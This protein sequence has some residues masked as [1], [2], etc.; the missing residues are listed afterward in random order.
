MNNQAPTPDA[1][2]AQLRQWLEDLPLLNPELSVGAVFEALANFKQCTLLGKTRLP[3]LH[4]YRGRINSLFYAYD[5]PSFQHGIQAQNRDLVRHQLGELS[6]LLEQAY[7]TILNAAELESS[8]YLAALYAALEQST[9]RLRHTFRTYGPIPA[10]VHRHIN[11][12]YLQAEQRG[13]LYTPVKIGTRSERHENISAL[14]KQLMLLTLADPFHLPEGE[15]MQAFTFLGRYAGGCRMQRE[16]STTPQSGIFFID[17]AANTPPLP[18]DRMESPMPPTVRAFDINPMV[19]AATRDIINKNASLK[20]RIV[21]EQA[22]W[23][24]KQFEPHL[25]AQ[26][27]QREKRRQSKRQTSLIIGLEMVRNRLQSEHTPA[28]EN[29]W[30]IVE[31]S[32][33][34]YRLS[35]KD[36]AEI[37]LPVGELVALLESGIDQ[38]YQ[39]GLTRWQRRNPMGAISL[40]L[41]KL[42]GKVQT[43]TC[44]ILNQP[45][46]SIP[47]LYIQEKGKQAY[48]LVTHRRLKEGTEVKL[49]LPDGKR[50]FKVGKASVCSPR[51]DRYAI[52]SME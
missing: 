7:A 1:Q 49:Q 42:V 44:M 12:Y 19:R 5:T 46:E 13:L 27:F 31:E 34:G 30:R 3:L 47:C 26:P 29:L 25:Q 18:A 41:E 6:K 23:L 21:A 35:G 43:A 45:S 11:T 2:P 15:A 9:H 48:L 32:T 20:H 37:R 39:L 16:Y 51:V 33:C 36:E 38:D 10:G 24:L 22:K 17:L 40:G 8:E 4:L 52:P 28:R 14:Y 50:A